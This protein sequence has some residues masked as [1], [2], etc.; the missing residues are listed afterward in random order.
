GAVLLG[1]AVYGSARIA[2]ASET[3][4]PRPAPERTLKDNQLKKVSSAMAAWLTAV[5]TNKDRGKAEDKLRGEVEKLN[6][7]TL[8]GGD[9]LALPEDLGYIVYQAN[10]YKKKEKL[11]KRGIGKV[12]SETVE[13]NGVTVEYAVWTPNGYSSKSGPYPTLVSIP[14]EGQ[15]PEEHISQYW[16]GSNLAETSI[17][18]CPKMPGNSKEW[19]DGAGLPA[20][21]YAFGAVQLKW[22]VD[23]NRVYIGGR[24][25]GGETA[26]MIANMF[27]KRF[28]AAFG[29]AADPGD[30]VEPLNL[31]HVPVM[32]SGGGKNATEFQT[33]AKD[34]GVESV[35]LDGDAD[36]NAIAAWLADKTRVAYPEEATVIPGRTF[37]TGTSWF[38]FSPVPEGSGARVD[39]S[40]DRE[41][42]TVSITAKGITELNVLFSDAMLDLSQP[43]KVVVNGVESVDKFDRSINQ[44]LGF[45]ES[46]RVD[47]SRIFVASKLYNVPSLEED[48]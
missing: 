39:G 11:V 12:M 2:P 20:I 27:P 23:S 46:T 6:K 18:V 10:D 41:T 7:K 24:G 34:A 28:A 30:G 8:K 19:V 29:W 48:N 14:E 44:F 36:A 45:V 22:A 42:N 16:M 17:V 26:V 38:Y 40:Y 3:V 4:A 35:E 21:F 43:V 15:S 31:K 25:L 5:D 1:S 32:V 47:P 13:R 33:R 9:I 37:P